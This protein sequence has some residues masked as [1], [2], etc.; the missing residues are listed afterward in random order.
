[1]TQEEFDNLQDGDEV[2][3][4]D[5]IYEVNHS[6]WTSLDKDTYTKDTVYEVDM[7]NTSNT[8]DGQPWIG[9]QL[10]NDGQTGHGWPMDRWDIYDPKVIDIYARL[11]MNQQGDED[12]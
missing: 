11:G 8:S 6:E 1:M 2:V 7:K 5:N 4:V 10:T 12:E 3:L 9:V